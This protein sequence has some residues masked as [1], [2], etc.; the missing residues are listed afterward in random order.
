M[1]LFLCPSLVKITRRN[2]KL[3]VEKPTAVVVAKEELE[4]ICGCDILSNEQVNVVS[5][6]REAREDQMS[7]A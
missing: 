1:L 6:R 7:G 4:L 5:V 2:R 3:I